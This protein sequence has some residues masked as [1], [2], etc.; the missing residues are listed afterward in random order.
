MD[1]YGVVV[2]AVVA[3]TAANAC[4]GVDGVLLLGVPG[5]G[6]AGARSSAQRASV[7]SVSD[8]I[9]DEGRADCCRAA[10]LTDVGQI[11][12][13]EIADCGQHWVGCCL[14]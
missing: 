3:G 2:A 8:L 11:L 10:V 6:V 13:A 12:V 5:Y 9:G 4:F 1:D 14:A 7:A